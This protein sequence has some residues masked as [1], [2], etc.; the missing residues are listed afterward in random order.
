[1]PTTVNHCEALT[2]TELDQ[3]QGGLVINLSVAVK[4]ND[5]GPD[6]QAATTPTRFDSYKN[7]KFR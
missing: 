2:D 6:A 7:F 1:M 5:P 3:A 4:D